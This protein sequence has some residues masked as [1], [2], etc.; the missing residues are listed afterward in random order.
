M[1]SRLGNLFMQALINSPLHSL[2]GN[3]LAVITVTGRRTGKAISTP[4]NIVNLEDAR[5]VISMRERTWWRNLRDGRQ[6]RISQ[7]GERFAVRAEVVE[8]PGD[9]AGWMEKYFLEY[10]GFAK[11]FGIQ[12]AA[13]RR[14]AAQ[15]FERLGRERV[16][17]RLH[18]S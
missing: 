4:I 7:A 3:N 16:V 2:L 8:T 1:P 14:P 12:L 6:A 10:P 18:P 17:I 9:V 5:T 11:Y 15:D 13:G